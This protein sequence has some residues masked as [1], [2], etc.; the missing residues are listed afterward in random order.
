M[1]D[2]W[3]CSLVHNIPKSKH[4]HAHSQLK[5]DSTNLNT[6]EPSRA[7]RLMRIGLK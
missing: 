6:R 4:L 5:T 3:P 2:H 1:K 7:H